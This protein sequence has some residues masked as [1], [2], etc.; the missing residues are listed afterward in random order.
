MSR[1]STVWVTL[2]ALNFIPSVWTHKDSALRVRISIYEVP[3]GIVSR[4]ISSQVNSDGSVEGTT[5]GGATTAK[6]PR[7]PVLL[8]NYFSGEPIPLTIKGMLREYMAYDCVRSQDITVHD[9]AQDEFVFDNTRS[10]V[11]EAGQSVESYPYDLTY[12]L[13]IEPAWRTAEAAGVRLQLWMDW[14][15]APDVQRAGTSSSEPL[16]LDQTIPVKF[17][18]TS[19]AGF[20]SPANGPRGFVYWVAVSADKR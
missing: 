20:R 13:R 4:T 15:N 8:Q 11:Q 16:I 6:F 1:V 5:A 10:L 7:T 14:K 19:F 18:Q 9:L 17:S 2:F 3:F 12:H